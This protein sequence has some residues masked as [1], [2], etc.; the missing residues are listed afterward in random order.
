MQI[1]AKNAILE[2]SLAGAPRGAA[3]KTIVFLP[4]WGR[5]KSDFDSL[6]RMLETRVPD[7]A[8]IHLDLPGFGGS[9]LPHDDG[10]G[11]SEYA[12]ILKEFLAKL[13]ADKVVVVGHSFGGKI[14]LRFSALFPD[15][16]EKLVLI[17]AAGVSK[18]SFF[19]RLA[20]LG[21]LMFRGLVFPFQYAH[22]VRRLRYALR[23]LL[24]S[25]DYRAT[26]SPGLQETLK[27]NLSD[28]S[29]RDAQKIHIPCLI[30]WG[31][32]DPV[33]PIRDGE[34]YHLLIPGSQLEVFPDCGHFPFLKYPER[35]AELIAS[36]VA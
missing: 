17:S 7:A 14:A 16:T 32:D 12:E 35:C 29:H 8:I 10:L 24:G 6:G 34:L 31:E 9:P 5:T 27:K 4:G 1:L 21:G 25:S 19:V 18:K 26:L 36:F 22:R 30:I 28:P 20:A 33:T 15:R 11:I 3:G 23:S 2:Y 13:G